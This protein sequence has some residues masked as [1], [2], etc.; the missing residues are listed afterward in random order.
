[1][2]N[3]GEYNKKI[4]IYQITQNE[5]N[6]GFKEKVES[7]VLTCYAKVKTTKGFTLI[8]GKCTISRVSHWITPP[9]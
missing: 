9:I 2:I 5:D 1:M 6:A 4:V 3:P 7:V 8:V